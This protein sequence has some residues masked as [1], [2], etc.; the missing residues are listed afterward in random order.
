MTPS[1]T[2]ATMTTRREANEQKKRDMLV[3]GGKMCS[4]DE[5]AALETLEQKVCVRVCA[6]E[7]ECVRDSFG[8]IIVYTYELGMHSRK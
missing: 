2:S 3:F 1:V 5:M 6:R 8:Y 7:R 4:D